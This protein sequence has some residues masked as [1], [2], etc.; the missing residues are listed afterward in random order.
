MTQ[1]SGPHVH[2]V[3]RLAFR[4]LCSSEQALELHFTQ[5]E[6]E[7]NRC[8]A[9]Y[10]Y[11]LSAIMRFPYVSYFSLLCS[12][13]I[14]VVRSISISLWKIFV[15]LSLY[16]CLGCISFIDDSYSDSNRDCMC[17]F[18]LRL[19]F[20]Q[21]GI[22]NQNE[23]LCMSSAMQVVAELYSGYR[24]GLTLHLC[25]VTVSLISFL[26]DWFWWVVIGSSAL[27]YKLQFCRVNLKV[28]WIT[29]VGFPTRRISSTLVLIASIGLHWSTSR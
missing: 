21:E 18:S 25:F 5:E 16:L 20:A 13:C 15:S 26:L 28:R 24:I 22:L 23:N 3:S 1:P 19:V 9:V 14:F 6:S 29:E 2:T 27:H 7:G 11:F 12:P 10:R 17:V 4:F 8:W